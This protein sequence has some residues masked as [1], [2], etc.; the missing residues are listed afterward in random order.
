MVQKTVSLASPLSPD[1]V[2]DGGCAP[3]SGLTLDIIK[4]AVIDPD[5]KLP[6]AV[7]SAY[8][9]SPSFQSTNRTLHSSGSSEVRA[10]TRRITHRLKRQTRLYFPPVGGFQFGGTTKNNGIPIVLRSLE[11]G[12]PIIF[13]VMNYR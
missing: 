3:V 7:V 8:K 11:L 13:V 6:V 10:S 12:E 2:L 5:I 1:F 9:P 4:P